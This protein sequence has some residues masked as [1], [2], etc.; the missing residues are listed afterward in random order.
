[1]SRIRFAMDGR[2]TAARAMMM[3]SLGS[4]LVISMIREIRASAGNL[5]F[6]LKKGSRLINIPGIAEMTT[7]MKN[8]STEA[9][10]CSAAVDVVD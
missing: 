4:E 1:M 8:M 9:I 6:S 10:T 3:I 5:T 2:E 7:T